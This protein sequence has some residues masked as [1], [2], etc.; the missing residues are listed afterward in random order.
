MVAD[1]AP[2]CMSDLDSRACV[3]VERF[4]VSVLTVPMRHRNEADPAYLPQ[5]ISWLVQGLRRHRRHCL[6]SYMIG[7]Y[8]RATSWTGL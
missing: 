5:S 6:D 7:V 1:V 8:A 2:T 4:L 3:Q